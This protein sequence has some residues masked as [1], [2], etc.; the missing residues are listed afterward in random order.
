MSETRKVDEI[1]FREDLYPR[2]DTS[3]TTVQKYADDLD[4]L[5]PVEVNQV[6][7]DEEGPPAPAAESAGSEEADGQDT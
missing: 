3:P 6:L 5:P 7:K 2:I 1:V 4:V